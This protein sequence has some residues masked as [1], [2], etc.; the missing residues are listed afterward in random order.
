MFRYR[1]QNL[2]AGLGEETAE[3][4]RG[5]RGGFEVDIKWNNGRLAGVKVKSLQGNSCRR[6]VMEK[7]FVI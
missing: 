6:Y 5:A 4:G 7:L 2:D 1:W 3:N